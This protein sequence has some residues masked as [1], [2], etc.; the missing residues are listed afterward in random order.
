MKEA[1]NLRA[2]LR[3]IAKRAPREGEMYT[4]NSAVIANAEA[5]IAELEAERDRLKANLVA[6]EDEK[7]AYI[8]YVGDTLGQGEDES[9]W[10]ASQRV[11]SSRDRFR[12]TLTALVRVAESRPFSPIGH[13]IEHELCEIDRLT[14]E[15]L[16]ETDHG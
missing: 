16:K 5:R 12:V 15:A 3:A 14:A 7:N 13:V 10:D 8:E 9:L 6:L 11:I 4:D 1:M 2:R